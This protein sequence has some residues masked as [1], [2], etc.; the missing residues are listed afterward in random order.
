M[1][2]LTQRFVSA[3][4]RARIDACVQQAERTT[5]G[6]IA[7]LIASASHAYPMAGMLGAA[8][9][10][11][12]LAVVVTRLVGELLWIGPSNLWLYL[13][14]WFPLFFIC[15]Q[16]VQVFH[17]LHRLFINEEEMEAEV[18]EAAVLNYYRH[19]L[20]RTPEEIGVLLYV[21]VFERRVW[22]LG[23]RGINAR[24]PEGFWTGIVQE[25]VRG[26]R[27]GRGADAIC[28][29]VERIALV[30]EEHFPAR[31]GDRDELRN[32]ILSG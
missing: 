14:V 21:S 4:D 15:R 31:P 30:L 2:D 10:S 1:K 9:F 25:A 8:V 17:F 27:E 18:Q 28:H 20:Y 6:E 16:A 23:G 24:I 26:V 22:V 12:P 11:I 32:L 13:G 29:A 5:R 7:V 19:G 3:P